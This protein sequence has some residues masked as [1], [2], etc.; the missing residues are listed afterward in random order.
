MITQIEKREGRPISDMVD[1]RVSVELPGADKVYAPKLSDGQTTAVAVTH[2]KVSRA[3]GVAAVIAAAVLLGLALV[4]L[5]RR[6]ARHR[7]R[8]QPAH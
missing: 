2:T 8:Y 3:V 6:F 5:R 7:R 1:V 4:L